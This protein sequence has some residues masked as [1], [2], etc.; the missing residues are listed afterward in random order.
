MVLLISS[1]SGCVCLLFCSPHSCDELN[2]CLCAPV[3]VVDNRVLSLYLCLAN[4]FGWLLT[5][6]LWWLLSHISNSF[7]Y[8]LWALRKNKCAW[9]FFDVT[10]SL[11][12]SWIS[13]DWMGT[14]FDLECGLWTRPGRRA[15]CIGLSAWPQSLFPLTT[16]DTRGEAV[17]WFLSP[18]HGLVHSTAR[19]PVRRLPPLRLHT[20]S[21]TSQEKAV[22]NARAA[23][24]VTLL[25]S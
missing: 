18:P 1:S 4:S 3:V 5:F 10:L 23:T 8:F 25:A 7:T 13:R 21:R 20:T 2:K 15:S 24:A 16:H 12:K 19:S 14:R 9:Q 17:A 6:L 22:Q 11:L